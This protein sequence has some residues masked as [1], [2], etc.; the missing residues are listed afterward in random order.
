[1]EEK[2]V[3]KGVEMRELHVPLWAELSI[4]KTWGEAIK[5]P[6][7][8]SYIPSEWRG[9]KGVD[10]VFFFGVLASLAPEYLITL[11]EDCRR[12]RMAKA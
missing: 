8:I 1:M 10:R 2:Q 9:G 7:F 11:I 5:Y 3:F 4:D 6:G 12:Q